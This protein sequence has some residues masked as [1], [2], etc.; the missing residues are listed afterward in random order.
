MQRYPSRGAVIITGAGQGIGRRLALTLVAEGV[1]VCIADWNE[2]KG[3]SVA[4]EEAPGTG[5]RLFVRTNVADEATC[6]AA[7]VATIEA[8]GG[9]F[10]LVNNASIFSTLTMRPFWEIPSE[11]WDQVQAVNLK[12]VFNMTRA[13]RQALAASGEGSVVNVASST[14]LF[15]RPNYAHYVSSKAGVL[16]LSR[17]MARELGDQSIRVNTL[18]PGPTFTEIER[19]TVTPQQKAAM[20]GQ[21]CLKRAGGPDDIADAIAFL[22]SRQARWITGQLLNADGGMIT[23]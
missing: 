14:I 9:V 6:E 13:A 21:Q 18:T 10:G 3:R 11:E 23:H 17:A 5:R 19:A 15:G 4:E 2:D 8:F 1:D 16:G 12:G 20:I 22:L 7:V